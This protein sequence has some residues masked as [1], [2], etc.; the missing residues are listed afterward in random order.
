MFTF[1]NYSKLIVSDFGTILNGG[2]ELNGEFVKEREGEC[3]TTMLKSI[4]MLG[5]TIYG[6]VSAEPLFWGKEAVGGDMQLS[7]Y[8][9]LKPS[10]QYSFRTS[11]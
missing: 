6:W 8:T 11:S 2:N 9:E 10:T 7:G 3:Y 5:Y 4:L 1:F